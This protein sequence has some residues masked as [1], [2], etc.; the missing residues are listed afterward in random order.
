MTPITLAP[1]AFL[2]GLLMFLAPCTLPMVPGY[3]AFVSGVSEEELQGAASRRAARR[4][5]LRNAVAFVL[6]FSLIFILLG[7]FAG[8]FGSILGEWRY[9]LGRAA[10]AILILFGLTMLG[11]FRLPVLGG[12][13][14][15]RLPKWLELGHP[16][17]SF[18]VGALFAIG[19]SPCIGPILGSILFLASASATA[20]QGAVLLA[21]FSAG[22]AVPFLITA[23]LIGEA[24]GALARMAGF[25]RGLQYVGGAVLLALGALMLLGQMGL[26]VDWG[27]R[28]FDPVGYGGLLN[29]L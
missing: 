8:L 4:R 14:H 2:A 15:A 7:V 19:W 1:A 21:I 20:A 3:L 18:V 22:L 23:F 12:Q 10:G 25:A 28:L 11:V 6:G 13:W 27:F 16:Q 26:L 5:V 9:A 17:S 29:H 24:A